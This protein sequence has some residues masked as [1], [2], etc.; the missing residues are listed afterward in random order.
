MYS[1]PIAPIPPACHPIDLPRISCYSARLE[2]S[3]SHQEEAKYLGRSFCPLRPSDRRV[4]AAPI[5]FWKTNLVQSSVQ[6]P[7]LSFSG[8]HQ[9]IDCLHFHLVSLKE[10]PQTGVFGFIFRQ[11]RFYPGRRRVNGSTPPPLYDNPNR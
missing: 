4:F 1:R 3:R 2:R 5:L 11:F 7:D 9:S 6:L 10:R 8:I